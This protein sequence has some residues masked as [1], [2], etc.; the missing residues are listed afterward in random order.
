MQAI[1]VWSAFCRAKLPI[2]PYKDR[3]LDSVYRN[4]AVA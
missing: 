1:A 4:K 2:E 3:P